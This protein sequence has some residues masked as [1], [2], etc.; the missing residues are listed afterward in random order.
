MKASVLAAAVVALNLNLSAAADL[1]DAQ[2]AYNEAGDAKATSSATRASVENLNTDTTANYN[3]AITFYN[4]NYVPANGRNAD[5]EAQ[6]S[7]AY[8]YFTTDAPNDYNSGVMQDGEGNIDLINSG[9]DIGNQSYDAAI[10]DAEN[11]EAWYNGAI[12][13]FCQANADLIAAQGCI[14]QANMLM[15]L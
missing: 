13:S 5:I 10:V 4:N 1:A 3:A 14:D 2:A 11:A 7:T 15:G 12:S 9:L 6:L 8:G